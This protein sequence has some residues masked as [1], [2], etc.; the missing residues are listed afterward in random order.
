M[1]DCYSK[2]VTVHLRKIPLSNMPPTLQYAIL[3]FKLKWRLQVVV[4]LKYF[5]FCFLVMLHHYLFQIHF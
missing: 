4:K 1:V 5:K 3:E 2:S